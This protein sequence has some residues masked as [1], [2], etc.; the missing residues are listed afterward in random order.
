[1]DYVKG[2][3]NG[4][5]CVKCVHCNM[6]TEI[7]IGWNGLYLHKA[8]CQVVSNYYAELERTNRLPLYD[9]LEHPPAYSE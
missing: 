1:M 2:K 4:R 3:I 5:L 8:V 7:L 9:E 6:I